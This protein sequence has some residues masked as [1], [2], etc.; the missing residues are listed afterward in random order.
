MGIG[1]TKSDA[2]EEIVNEFYDR[3]L[4]SCI[5]GGSGQEKTIEP[6][7]ADLKLLVNDGEKFLKAL[8]DQEGA[9]FMDRLNQSK[10]QK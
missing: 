3:V 4:S 8:D 6:K 10:P 5:R 1:G 9:D 7:P 2:P